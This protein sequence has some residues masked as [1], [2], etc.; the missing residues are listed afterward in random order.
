MHE[1]IEFQMSLLLAVALA[2]HLFAS[3]VRQPAVVG[4]I[5]AGLVIG[6]S[7]L[8]W[9]TYTTFVANVAHLGAIVLLFVVGLEFRI[10][11]LFAARAFLMALAGVIVPWLTGYWLALGF[12]F[13]S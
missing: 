1:S 11:E 10:K 8:G 12:G 13:E 6:P 2:G 7:L 4:Q 9:V 5:I 3:L